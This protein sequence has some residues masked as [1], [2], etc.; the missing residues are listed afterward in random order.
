M[1]RVQKS[2]HPDDEFHY[3]K[4][5]LNREKVELWEDGARDNAYSAISLAQSGMVSFYDDPTDDVACT[6]W[7]IAYRYELEGEVQHESAESYEYED[8]YYPAQ[9]WLNDPQYNYPDGEI[10]VTGSASSNVEEGGGELEEGG[11][12][13]LP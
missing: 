5:G 3:Q 9:Y 11:E 7:D 4:M 6:T 12:I 8:D 13:L 1:A 10:N 2:I